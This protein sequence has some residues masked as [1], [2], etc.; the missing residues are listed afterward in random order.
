MFVKHVSDYH[1][2]FHGIEVF[3]RDL[4][5]QNLVWHMLHSIK[6]ATLLIKVLHADHQF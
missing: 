4:K 1:A 6:D 2:K 5:M 3:F